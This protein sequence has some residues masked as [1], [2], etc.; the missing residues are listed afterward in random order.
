MCTPGG[1]CAQCAVDADCARGV[2]DAGDCVDPFGCEADEDCLDGRTCSNGFCDLP[3]NACEDDEVN[4]GDFGNA[5]PLLY[6]TIPNL[7]ACEGPGDWFT[8]NDPVG[9]RVIV[10]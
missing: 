3:R 6:A 9:A 4:N 2:C 1:H 5:E 8:V 10:V 7:V